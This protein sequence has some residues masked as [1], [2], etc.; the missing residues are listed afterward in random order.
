MS[1][2][3]HAAGLSRVHVQSS[4]GFLVDGLRDGLAA[5]GHD[6]TEIVTVGD[7]EDAFVAALDDM[8]ALI[9]FH[10]P[11]GH[12][13][14]ARTLRLLQVPGAGVDSVLPAPDLGEHVTVCNAVGIHLPEMAE[15]A[16]GMVL[17][18]HLDVPRLV[19]QQRRREWRWVL[20]GPLA[21]RRA[22]VVG[23]GHIGEAIAAGL[24]AN[25][26]RVDGV[27][28]SGAPVEGIDRVVDS[29]RRLEVLTGADVVVVVVPLTEATTGLIG[30]A[31]LGALAEGALLVDVSR[32]GV[33][34]HH[35]L[36]AALE[37]GRV[38]GAALDVFDTEPLPPDDA[39][40]DVPGLLVTPH[41]A[42]ISP[43][44]FGRLT[45]LCVDNLV[46]LAEG[47]E[48]RNVV[49]RSRGY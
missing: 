25:G 18:L 10:P 2:D 1:G 19:D 49:D 6:D 21:G 35:A 17:A 5:A 22:V 26:L 27:S 3:S 15:F 38:R 46:R 13:A 40:W 41:I 28:R 29:S 34:D 48:L 42:A 9:A 33:V 44:Y 14:A 36:V 4:L 23:L 37:R 43:D 8:E 30:T 20:H 32:G 7:D 39:R 16:V 47:R 45:E 11:P 12:W 31:E 24:A